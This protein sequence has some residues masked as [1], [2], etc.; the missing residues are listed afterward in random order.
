MNHGN[1][2]LELAI[3]YK[4]RDQFGIWD[5]EFSAKR[6]LKGGR[7]SLHH[8]MCGLRENDL[9]EFEAMLR[10]PRLHKLAMASVKSWS[11]YFAK[12]DNIN[13]TWIYSKRTE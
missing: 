1:D 3:L 12:R 5:I 13:N 11:V 2:T 7:F 8:Y 6:G 9:K 10:K 4:A